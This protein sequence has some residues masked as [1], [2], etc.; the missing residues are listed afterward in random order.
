M[1]DRVQALESDFDALTTG[2]VSPEI[3][4]LNWQLEEFRLTTFAQQIAT[5]SPSSTGGKVSEKKIRAA[6]RKL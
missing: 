4:E 3:E 2:R 1:M 6:L 5:R